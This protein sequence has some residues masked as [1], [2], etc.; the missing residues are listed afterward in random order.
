MTLRHLGYTIGECVR[1]VTAGAAVVAYV[2]FIVAV[3]LALHIL[4]P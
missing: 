2:V 4:A 3:L 1:S